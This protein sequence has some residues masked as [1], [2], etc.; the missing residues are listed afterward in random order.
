MDTLQSAIVLSKLKVYDKEI[1][2]RIK[3]ANKYNS[4]F[5][6]M[7]IKYMQPQKISNVLKRYALKQN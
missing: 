3:I 1:K 5:K 6:S 7:N 2:E 4:F